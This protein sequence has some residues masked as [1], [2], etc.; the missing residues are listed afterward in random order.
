MCL[1]TH[2]YIRT[3]CTYT[4]NPCACR[5]AF[6]DMN[7]LYIS[8]ISTFSFFY[9]NNFSNKFKFNSILTLMK[10]KIKS[11]HLKS[12]VSFEYLSVKSPAKPVNPAVSVRKGIV[13][14]D[15]ESKMGVICVRDVFSKSSD[16]NSVNMVS[17]FCFFFIILSHRGFIGFCLCLICEEQEYIL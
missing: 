16:T 6:M 17:H 15:P 11:Q 12:R 13:A 8:S 9:Y 2:T 14:S 3:P 4:P 1:S 10:T 7:V 5:N